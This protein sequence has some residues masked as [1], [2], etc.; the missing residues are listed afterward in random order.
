[1]L[2]LDERQHLLHERPAGRSCVRRKLVP[3]RVIVRKAKFVG[4]SG[5]SIAMSCSISPMR[6]GCKLHL[7]LLSRARNRTEAGQAPGY[8]RDRK[9]PLADMRGFRLPPPSLERWRAR[10]GWGRIQVFTSKDAANAVRRRYGG[11]TQKEVLLKEI[12]R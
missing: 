2:E 11:P 10:G 12:K 8:R 4:L 1:M 6:R 5:P 9:S 3:F 7:T